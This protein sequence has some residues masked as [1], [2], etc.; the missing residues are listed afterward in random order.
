MAFYRVYSVSEPD[1]SLEAING[2]SVGAHSMSKQ[3]LALQPIHF[4]SS[5]K[6]LK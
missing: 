6:L 1:S 2:F 3:A 5:T 4:R